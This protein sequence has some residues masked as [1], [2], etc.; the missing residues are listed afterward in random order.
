MVW[1]LFEKIVSHKDLDEKAKVDSQ[2]IQNTI[3][4]LFWFL[5]AHENEGL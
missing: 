2:R 1:K 4:N 3:L 5:C